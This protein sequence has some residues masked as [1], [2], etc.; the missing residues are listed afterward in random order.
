MKITINQLR[1]I[2][3]EETAKVLCEGASNSDIQ[4]AIEKYKESPMLWQ[5]VG[6][7]L[8]DMAMGGDAG[9]I[10]ADYY[11]GWTDAD[12]MAVITAIEPGWTPDDEY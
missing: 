3:K 9:G 12:F 10:R 7:E 6:N 2:I 4:L 8:K 5:M 1:R 11:K